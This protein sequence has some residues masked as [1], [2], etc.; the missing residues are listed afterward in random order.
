MLGETAFGS[1]VSQSDVSMTARLF[2]SLYRRLLQ[3]GGP[4]PDIAAPSPEPAISIDSLTELQRSRLEELSTLM[5]C[6]QAQALKLAR[7]YPKVGLAAWRD[8]SLAKGEVIPRFLP[9]DS[10]GAVALSSRVTVQD[11]IY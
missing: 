3:L 10:E 6:S 7:N 9:T 8:P 11:L 2:G 1:K 4:H 5:A